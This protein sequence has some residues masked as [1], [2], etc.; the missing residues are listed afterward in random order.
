MEKTLKVI[1]HINIL[2][3]RYHTITLLDIEKAF[4]KSQHPFDLK[5][6]PER[7]GMDAIYLNIIKAL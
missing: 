2:I 7:L 3:D 6:T 1:H 4:D 5:K